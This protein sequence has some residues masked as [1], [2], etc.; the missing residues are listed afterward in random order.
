MVSLALL[1]LG[2]PSHSLGEEASV[3][4]GKRLDES[5]NNDLPFSK[6]RRL[7]ER[8]L[9]NPRA[10]AASKSGNVGGEMLDKADE[11]LTKHYSKKREERRYI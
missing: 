7:S 11:V 1:V 10:M 8:S 9:S 3:N 6:L 5:S 4:K 2:D